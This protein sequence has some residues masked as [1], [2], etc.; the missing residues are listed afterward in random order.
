MN[1]VY[2]IVVLM[3]VSAALFGQ[4][5]NTHA[6]QPPL[7]M[8]RE[9]ESYAYLKNKEE[10]PYRGDFFDGIKYLPLN[11]SGSA[12]ASFGGQLRSRYEYF[13]HRFWLPG[14]TDFY[15]QRLALHTNIV[16]GKSLRFYGELYHG[17]TSHEKV[18][19][20]YDKADV[21]QVFA[22]YKLRLTQKQFIMLR[23]G[24][25]QLAFGANRLV[26][27]REGPNI[28]RSFD[29]GR[30]IYK[31]NRSKIEAFYGREVMPL[32]EAFDN[33]FSLFNHEA[34]N[35]KLWG[36][37]FHFPTRVLGGRHEF[38]Y[39]GF[40]SKNV[41]FNEVAGKETRHTIGMRRFGN[42]TK[43]WTFNTEIIYQFGEAGGNR[44]NAFSVAS[45]GRYMLSDF[46][47][48]PNIGLKLEYASGD[49]NAGDG[50]VQSF[51]PMFVNPAYY[52]LAG[53]IT[54]V[55]LVSVHPFVGAKPSEKLRIYAEWAM[56]WRASVQD[57]LYRPT[58]F[59]NRPADG[60][61]SRNI[62]HQFGLIA[63]YEANRHLSFDLNASYFIAGNFLQQSGAAEHILHIAP[64]LHYKF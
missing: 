13:S 12:Y 30:L 63:K 39:L 34:V 64:T 42:L 6:V 26:G 36:I 4:E 35:D 23:L 2:F 41:A 45:D 57:G 43:E 19:A 29:M 21:F 44:I 27:L 24:R 46:R 49:Q 56:F 54:P 5:G 37:Y 51:N 28:R 25:Q 20:E 50:K 47:W 22:D 16:L 55:N 53:T 60:N 40:Q 8:L 48:K 14:N 61:K 18:F 52:S 11:R 1:K 17:Y 33:D 32:F 9:T 10:M 3:L 38:Y 59:I 58:R 15:S 7:S 31:V 62:G